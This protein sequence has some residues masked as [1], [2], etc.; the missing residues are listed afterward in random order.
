MNRGRLSWAGVLL[1]AACGLWAATIL[2]ELIAA[3]PL[4]STPEPDWQDAYDSGEMVFA[5]I[6]ALF[7]L[8]PVSLAAVVVLVV[9]TCRQAH[10]A[11]V[12]LVLLVAHLGLLMWIW[13]GSGSP[14]SAWEFWT[15]LAGWLSCAVTGIAAGAGLRPNRASCLGESTSRQPPRA[16]DV[17]VLP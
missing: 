4:L 7:A 1:I 10:L 17:D 3:Q 6:P 8:L 9:V 5:S 12:G 11:V 16:L 15:R 13:T 2:L 14:G